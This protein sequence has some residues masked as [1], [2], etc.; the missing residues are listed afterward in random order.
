[1]QYFA[2]VESSSAGNESVTLTACASDGPLLVTVTVNWTV[3]RF[4]GWVGSK[5]RI[6]TFELSQADDGGGVGTT[7]SEPSFVTETSAMAMTETESVLE[8]FEETSSVGV[9]VPETSAAVFD[10][11]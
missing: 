5:H 9:T 7:T 4:P 11:V 3:F 8:L 6:N 10:R 1:M 2:L